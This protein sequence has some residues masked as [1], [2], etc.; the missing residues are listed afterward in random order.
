[1]SNHQKSKRIYRLPPCPAYDVETMESWLG[2]MAEQGWV[3]EQDGF[4]FGFGFA[5]FRRQTPQQLR[6][7]LEAA[8]KGTGMF[9]E[10]GGQPNPEAQELA[11]ALGWKYAASRGD[12][13][14]FVSDQPGAPELN[15]DPAVQAI[16]LKKARSNARTSLFAA[17][18]WAALWPLLRLR[19]AFWLTAVNVG[20]PMTL[21][22]LGLIVWSLAWSLRRAIH[23]GK[24]TR[25]LSRG[26]PLEH[27]KDW[28]SQAARRRAESLS[29]CALWVLWLCLFLRLWAL[30]LE[31][32]G[33]VDLREYQ[34][35][36]PFASMESLIPGGQFSYDDFVAGR[37]NTVSFRSNWLAPQMISFWQ[38]GKVQGEGRV[39]DGGIRVEYYRVR[40]PWLARRMAEE[41]KKIDKVRNRK[42][43]QELD[44][45]S[46]QDLGVDYAS[47][48]TSVFP[49]LILAKGDAM[50]RVYFYQTQDPALPLEE[51]AAVFAA[52]LD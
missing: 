5:A 18:F 34:G 32:P 4:L 7:R 40:W 6:Y 8:S 22:S 3:L 13:Y 21:L 28:R 29:Y 16:A 31:E 24:L 41:Y 48:Y 1:M 49:T 39:I 26:L 19:G 45:P 20:L 10:N 23:L 27:K 25:R 2:A 36:L 44:C 51:W 52:S 47:A 12:F 35:E 14:I 50:L 43:Y 33:K 9:S 37:T 38:T 42:Y 30:D 15:T 46:A 11:L 17:L